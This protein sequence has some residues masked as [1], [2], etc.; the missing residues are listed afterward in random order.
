MSRTQET[1]DPLPTHCS[2]TY[3]LYMKL[4]ETVCS[5]Q[6]HRHCF[7]TRFV[8]GKYTVLVENTT[9]KKSIP[10]IRRYLRI[11]KGS[12]PEAGLE[13][14]CKDTWWSSGRLCRYGIAQSSGSSACPMGLPLP[15]AA[16][17][18]NRQL[19]RLNTVIVPLQAGV[20]LGNK[21]TRLR[22]NQFP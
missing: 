14:L 6:Q 9:S 15:L 19:N 4:K 7:H 21:P 5:F 10:V 2:S 22:F 16:F 13:C 17:A 20:W 18:E 12:L 3:M 11:G 8:M 1:T